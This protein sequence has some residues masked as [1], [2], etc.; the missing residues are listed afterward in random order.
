MNTFRDYELRILEVARKVLLN[1]YL[2]P[3]VKEIDSCLEENGR[4]HIV[5]PTVDHLALSLLLKILVENDPRVF[6]SAKF[7]HGAETR[8]SLISGLEMNEVISELKNNFNPRIRIGYEVEKYGNY[9]ISL[10]MP[11]KYL[12]WAPDPSEVKA[13]NQ[14]RTKSENMVIGFLGGAKERKGFELIPE[15]IANISNSFPNSKFLVHG[16]SFKWKGYDITEN[17]LRAI[18]SDVEIFEGHISE[19]LLG[20]L[21]GRC[22]ALILPYDAISYSMAA[23][24][25]VYQSSNLLVPVLVSEGTGFAQECKDFGIGEI[26]SNTQEVA[27]KLGILLSGDSR[28]KIRHYN[29]KRNYVAS[30]FLDL[31]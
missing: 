21:I 26:F 6:V 30:E 1:F 29:L 28:E 20:E 7:I 11:T 13:H 19:L 23:S 12:Y 31:I 8:G 14:T 22:D 17:K 2:A 27:F 5:F 15:I 24:A 9:L 16:T 18:P 25:V 10:G 4:I 3:A